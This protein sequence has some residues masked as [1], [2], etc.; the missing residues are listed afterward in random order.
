MKRPYSRKTINDM[1]ELAK[2]KKGKCLSKIYL[3]AHS[4]L[5]WQCEFG[6]VWETVPNGIIYGNHWCPACANIRLGKRSALKD[7]F[8]KM[9]SLATSKGGKCLSKNYSGMHDRL[10]WQ[11]EFGHI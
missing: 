5:K 1:H 8:Q 4:K 6:H 3:N 10:K 7:G 9:N 2:S 11:C